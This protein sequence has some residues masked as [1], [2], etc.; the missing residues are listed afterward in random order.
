METAETVNFTRMADGTREDYEF[1]A[2]LE[3]RRVD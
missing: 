1:L 3:R 2:G